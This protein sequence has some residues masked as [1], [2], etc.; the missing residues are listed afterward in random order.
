MIFDP[1]YIIMIA[2]VLIFS[3]WAGHKVKSN[4]KKFS[5]IASGRG[6]TGAQTAEKIL[7]ANGVTNV[8]IEHISGN[9]TD[10]YSPREK[11]LR[12]S[13][14]VYNSTSI[15]AIG[16][17]A[18]EAGH[19]L[20]HAKGYAVMGLWQMLAKPASR[21]SLLAFWLFMLG[22]LFSS[23]NLAMVGIVLF[24][25]VILFQLVTLPLEFNASSR[26]KRMIVE[27][28]IL[29]RSE[30]FGVSKVLN[31]AALT[32]IAAAASSIVTLLYFLIRLG[33]L[34]GDD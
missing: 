5:H 31:A 27:H 6:I 34:G 19:A 3:F 20:Q 29:D 7:H 16:V 2:P 24:S 25:V 32:Y 11:V 26:A 12:L 33:L 18:H 13:D 15:A 21:G 8:S 23:L 28:G 22:M 10:H 4:F 9:L 14:S 1:L 30:A 17:A